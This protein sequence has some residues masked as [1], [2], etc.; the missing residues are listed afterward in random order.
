M[1]HPISLIMLTLSTLLLVGCNGRVVTSG[2]Y[3]LE[4]G[5]TLRGDLTIFSG[6]A[7]LEEGS[8]VTG[9]VFMTSG[10]LDA[11][12][13]IDGD[14]FFTSGNVDL[15]PEAVVLGDI[16]ATSGDVRRAEG[17]RVEGEVSTD[18]GNFAIPG[19]L[20][21]GLMGTFCALPL[22]FLALL[23]ALIVIFARRRPTPAPQ[24]ATPAAPTQ[25]LQQ[26]QEMLARDLITEAEFEAK[27]ADI[28]ARM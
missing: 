28:L 20:I 23:I 9:D 25:K 24:T 4:S 15:G 5:K 3:T 21:A 27:K 19:G 8:R 18:P 17:A 10:N 13:E 2:N 1:R 11:N 14:I 7:T 6:D 16:L 12:G 26:L 22:V